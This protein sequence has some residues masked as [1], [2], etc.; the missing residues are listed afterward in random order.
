MQDFTGSIIFLFF[1]LIAW[2][3]TL[4]L[5]TK[6]KNT[7]KN[8]SKE[9]LSDSV[10]QATTIIIEQDELIKSLK[11][12]LKDVQALLAEHTVKKG[13]VNNE[14]INKALIPLSDD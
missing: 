4:M 3:I 7:K 13:I 8:L 9:K 12:Q 1:L 14:Q 11:I 10:L 2:A 5:G 6:K